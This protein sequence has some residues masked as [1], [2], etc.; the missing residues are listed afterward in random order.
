[1][2]GSNNYKIIVSA[3]I[4][5]AEIQK[6]L[7]QFSKTAKIKVDSSGVKQATKDVGLLGVKWADAGKKFL[8]WKVIGDVFSGVERAITQ[9]VS[10]VYEL[11]TALTEFNKVTNLSEQQLDKFIDK[12]YEAGKATAKTGRE[13]VEA[14]T[15]F[16][17]SGFSADDSLVLAKFATMYQNIADEAISAGDAAGFIIS[18]IKAFNMDAKDAEK[19]ISAVNEVSNNYAVSSADLA[20]NLGKVSATMA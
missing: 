1:M 4:N 17:K 15:E 3:E 16:A 13:M 9:M 2:A 10:S 7:N 20:N 12:A 5:T 8:A 6:Q 19:I 11:D 18:Q 14:S